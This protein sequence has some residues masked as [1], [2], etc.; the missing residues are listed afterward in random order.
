ML[1][2]QLK[3]A[4]KQLE[5]HVQEKAMLTSSVSELVACVSSQEQDASQA[6]EELQ[7]THSLVRN[8]LAIAQSD[9]EG[10]LRDYNASTDQNIAL[11]DEL[12][13]SKVSENELTKVVQGLKE[14]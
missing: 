9:L 4:D 13:A 12:T 11:A 14:E 2:S 5:E 10:L 3:S 6:I 1:V 7:H 8:K